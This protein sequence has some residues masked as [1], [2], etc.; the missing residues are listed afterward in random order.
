[1]VTTRAENA[2]KRPGLVDKPSSTRRTPDE[3]AKERQEKEKQKAAAQATKDAKVKRVEQATASAE[4][5]DT[6]YATPAAPRMEKK[7]KAATLQRTTSFADLSQYNAVDKDLAP[8][9]SPPP[10]FTRN[11][12]KTK[13]KPLP[14]AAAVAGTKAKPV[15]RS[16]PLITVGYAGGD[17]VA[18]AAKRSK[19]AGD[20]TSVNTTAFP[21]DD[22]GKL[23]VS[24][25][26]KPKATPGVRTRPPPKTSQPDVDV[27][28]AP[29]VIS[30]P[31]LLVPSAAGRPPKG[32]TSG[33]SAGPTAAHNAPRNASATGRAHRKTTE[34]TTDVESDFPAP[35]IR[36]E[37]SQRDS[38]TEESSVTEDD[39]QAYIPPPNQ[40]DSDTE[41]SSEPQA[42]LPKK[43]T[44]KAGGSKTQR[45][46][47]N[48]QT[49]TEANKQKSTSQRNSG[50][51][52]QPGSKKGKG[53][54]V[55][56]EDSEIEI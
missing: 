30:K 15:V 54:A 2:G 35:K 4:V 6:A 32:R 43:T 24:L 31:V 16:P 23:T 52:D 27:E 18:P 48:P 1:M 51:Q 42:T 7:R 25:G 34:A 10:P 29:P 53:R 47:S 33:N 50:N 40:P 41:S 36:R 55:P 5:E 26:T 11:E 22:N 46:K 14:K 9:I 13:T 21:A 56:Q 49:T 38:V 8:A 17:I 12:A 45:Q 37:E 28:M 19:S 39:S 3:V 44:V 20:T